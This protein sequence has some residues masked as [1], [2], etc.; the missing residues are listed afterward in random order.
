M[1]LPAKLLIPAPNLQLRRQARQVQE[2]L[3]QELA[4]ELPDLNNTYGRAVLYR[5]A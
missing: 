3:L 2:G 4:P 5:P 1:S